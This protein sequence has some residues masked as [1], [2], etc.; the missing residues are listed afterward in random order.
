[1]AESSKQRLECG[2]CIATR[3]R[4]CWDLLAVCALQ[5]GP[6]VQRGLLGAAMAEAQV[7]GGTRRLCVPG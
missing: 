4:S 7:Q 1:M 2:A 3:L 6:H 5:Q